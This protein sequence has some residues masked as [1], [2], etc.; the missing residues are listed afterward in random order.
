MIRFNSYA[1]MLH[2]WKIRFLGIPGD[3][4]TG[5]HGPFSLMIYHDLPLENDDTYWD[6]WGPY[7]ISPDFGHF[8]GKYQQYCK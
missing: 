7:G 3:L 4:R 5:N 1:K 2:L 8:T 6:T